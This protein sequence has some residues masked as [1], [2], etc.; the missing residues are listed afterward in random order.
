MKLSKPQ[1]DLLT[2]AVAAGKESCY[3]EY[4]PAKK[5]IALGLATSH[6]GRMGGYWVEP[7]PAGR[8][9]PQLKD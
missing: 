6:E 5:L 9:H 8:Q 4:Q 7:T 2:A 3:S 1:L